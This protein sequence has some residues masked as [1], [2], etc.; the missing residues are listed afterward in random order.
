V[1]GLIITYGRVPAIVV[2]L[3]TMSVFRGI[4]SL[5]AGGTQVSADQVPQTWLDM[6]SANIFGVPAIILIAVATLAGR[7]LFPALHHHRPR[8]LCDR[9]QPGWRP[10][11]GIPA[12]PRIL[13]AFA[14]RDCWPGLTGRFGRLAMPPSMPVLPSGFELTV[15]A[16]V[17]VGGVAVRGGSGTVLGVAAGPLTC[18][19]S[20][21]A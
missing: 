6:T 16:A 11:I 15:I 3:G 9:I 14:A 1:N 7:R 10:L 19:S 17:V 12:R 20:I 13:L 5:W 18:W 8:T 2:T 21:T 4:N